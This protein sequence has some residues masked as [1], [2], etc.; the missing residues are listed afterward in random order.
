MIKL[1]TYQQDL[2]DKVHDKLWIDG[3]K[4]LCV[5]L[6]TGGGKSVLI[7]KLAQ[8][9]PGRTLIL[10]H[11]IEILNQNG[12]LL[13]GASVLT[14]KENTL[15]NSNKIV[16]AMVQTAFA[17]IKKYG[18]K[19]LG[20]FDNIILDEVQILIFEKVFEQYDFNKLI[21]FTGTPVLEKKLYTT[22][23]E[24][25][26]I[27]PFTLSLIFDEL[28][29]GLDTQDLIDMGYLVQDYNIVLNLPDFY[30]LKD[31]ES[32]PDGY[33]I[34]SLNE[35]YTNEASLKILREAYD[36]YCLGKKTM[37]FNAST[38]INKKVYT[39]FKELGLN[40]KIYDT[41]N[42]TEINPATDKPFTRTEIIDWFRSERDAILINTN[43][44]T[45]GFDVDDV[46]CIIM[47]RATKSL[48]LWIQIIGRGS[49]TTS[50]I[51]K[52]KFTVI[53][54]GQNIHTHGIWS[55][56]RDWQNWFVSPGKKRK[57]KSDLLDT[58]ECGNCG[59]YNI[60]GDTTCTVCGAEKDNAVIK[61]SRSKKL[62][63]GTLREYGETPL[64][65]AIPII[66]YCKSIGEGSNFAYSLLERKIIDLFIHYNVAPEF[67]AKNKPK[68]ANRIMEIYRPI[69]FAIMK[70]ELKG[71][72]KRLVTQLNKLLT[73][74]D[75]MYGYKKE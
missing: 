33:T 5:A 62:K 1:R 31:S 43:V 56:R 47:N 72:N 27:E 45:T 40:V 66:N 68:F 49:R 57:N 70:S 21:G 10:T 4:K 2:Y 64:P 13:K 60:I 29:Q 37:I 15:R 16:I 25:E 20:D 3:V 18:I 59:A 63:D 58:W 39:N 38:Q 71:A 36:K 23:D 48:A 73:K 41:V 24:V 52:D 44:F 32:N 6:P 46:E 8:E 22:I 74:I 30:K 12:A 35:V 7:A 69:Y 50:K 14:A 9:L 34:D 42:E 26:Y 54:L 11:R 55:M 17:R 28:V 65:K 75:K 67:Y 53:D 61:E 51:F 19:Y